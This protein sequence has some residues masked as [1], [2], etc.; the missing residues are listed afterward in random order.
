MDRMYR[1]TRHVYDASRRFYLLGRDHLLQTMDIRPDDRVLEMGCGTARNLIQLHRLHPAAKLYGLDASARMLA[2]AGRSMVRR[3]FAAA[4]ML[5]QCLAEDLS[6]QKVF[7]SDEPFDVIFFSYS[8]S[9]MPTWPAALDAA[10]A[11]LKP[12]GRIY[13]VDF[14]DQAELPR[15]FASLLTRWL[16]LFHVHYRPEL[17][18]HLEKLA[19]EG[20][21]HLTVEPVARRYAYIGTISLAL[22]GIA[23]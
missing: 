5:C 20:R 15:W 13:I 23:S 10:M 1:H 12:G 22:T 7:E 6:H 16:A 17:M 2:T 21:C 19:A 9:M 3:N 14:W 4:I 18:A 8:L 11:N